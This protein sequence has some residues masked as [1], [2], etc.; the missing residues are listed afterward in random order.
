MRARGLAIIAVVF[1]HVNPGFGPSV[2][3]FQIAAFFFLGGMTMTAARPWLKVARFVAV[4]LLVYA[5]ASTLFYAIVTKALI[6]LGVPFPDFGNPLDLR[7][8]TSDL[9]ISNGHRISLALTAWFLVAYASAV[10]IC[11]TLV[12]VVPRQLHNWVLPVISGLLF[13][14]GVAYLAHDFDGPGGWK[15]NA[16]SHAAVGSALMLFGYVFSRVSWRDWI[17]ASQAAMVLTWTAYL[18]VCTA[19]RPNPFI[20]MV[21]STY[22]DGPLI[23]AALNGLGILGLIQLAA[24]LSGRNFMWLASIGAT[25]KTIMMHHLFVLTLVNLAFVALG[26]MPLAEVTGPYAKLAIAYTW[27]IYLGLGVAIP[28]MFGVGYKRWR[29]KRPLTTS[30]TVQPGTASAESSPAPPPG[31]LPV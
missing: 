22:P 17:I 18:W 31:T 4:D 12:R 26:L 21:F 25:S 20:G 10:L 5:A 14:L 28:W 9:V 24:V 1:G 15:W 6:A 23:T 11:E 13:W 16:A 19:F 29:S 27:P 30:V 3:H 8:Y 7:L 2:Q